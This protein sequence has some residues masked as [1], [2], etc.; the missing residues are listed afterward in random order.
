M[1]FMPTNNKGQAFSP[2]IASRVRPGGALAF[3]EPMKFD[4]M[5][6]GWV[7]VS[8]LR[9]YSEPGRPASP[10]EVNGNL[11]AE[12]E[13]E[14]TVGMSAEALLK[15][16]IKLNPTQSKLDEAASV[17]PFQYAKVKDWSGDVAERGWYVGGQVDSPFDK[18]RL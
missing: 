4:V 15:S 13:P 16:K 9:G 8:Q 18:A 3:S 17:N 1:E 6:G 10:T 11:R 5:K 7:A 12:V 14:P 2:T